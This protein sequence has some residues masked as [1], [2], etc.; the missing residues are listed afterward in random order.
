MENFILHRVLFAV[1]EVDLDFVGGGP[2]PMG[3]VCVVR[4][5]LLLYI[6]RTIVYNGIRW[7][8]PAR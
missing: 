5:N 2:N 6:A 4:V 8:V 1:A 7:A 3:Q